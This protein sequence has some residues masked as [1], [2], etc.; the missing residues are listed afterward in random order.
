MRKADRH[1]IDYV[2]PGGTTLGDRKVYTPET[3]RAEYLRRAAPESHAQEVEEGYIKGAVEEAPAVIS[4]NMR[5]ASACMNEFILRRY[6][7]RIDPNRGYARTTFSLAAGEEDF[8]DEDSFEKRNNP[9]LGRGSR[10][11]L[12]GL[13]TLGVTPAETVA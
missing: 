6:P 3:L 8:Y 10:E 12:L 9:L 11:P 2:Q 1:G 7:F 4:L 13:P 5:A